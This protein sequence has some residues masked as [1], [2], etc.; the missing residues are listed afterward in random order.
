MSGIDIS[1]IPRK[2]GGVTHAY[3]VGTKVLIRDN[4]PRAWGFVIQH[5]LNG[6]YLVENTW[7]TEAIDFHGNKRMTPTTQIVHEYELLPFPEGLP[8]VLRLH[9]III[10]PQ[11]IGR[12]SGEWCVTAIGEYSVL[13]VPHG[14]HLP[15]GEPWEQ[16][17]LYSTIQIKEHRV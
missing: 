9:D 14:W 7:V 6:Q 16:Q 13:A 12:P 10:I 4:T 5:I 8:P 3:P 1:D 2:Y 15:F 17:F 11:N